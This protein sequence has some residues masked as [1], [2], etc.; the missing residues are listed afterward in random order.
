[1]INNLRFSAKICVS[2]LKALITRIGYDKIICVS[3]RQPF[4]DADDR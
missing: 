3:L 4:L 2:L 1:M